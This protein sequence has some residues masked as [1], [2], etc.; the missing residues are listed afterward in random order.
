MSCFYNDQQT[1]IAVAFYFHLVCYYEH[2]ITYEMRVTG[3]RAAQG[4][5]N[6]FVLYLDLKKNLTNLILIGFFLNK[7][8]LKWHYFYLILIR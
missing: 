6:Y 3:Q 8:R 1:S 7:T 4:R 2:T 5:A